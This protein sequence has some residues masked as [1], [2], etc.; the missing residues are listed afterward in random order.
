M[1]H[2]TVIRPM[3]KIHTLGGQHT[4]DTPTLFLFQLE[5]CEVARDR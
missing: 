3:A 2:H 4:K 1:E 5:M